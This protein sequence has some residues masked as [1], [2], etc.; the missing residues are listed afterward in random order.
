MD[1]IIKQLTDIKNKL[2]KPFPYKDTD[3]IQEDFRVEFLNLSEEE[4]CLTGDFNTY[5]MNIAGTLSYVLSGKTDKIPKRQIE[6]LQ[7]SFFDFFNQYKFFEE[8]INNYL[9][10]Y[11]EYKNFEETRKLLLQ[12]VK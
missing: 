2:D 5:C 3:R 12:V 6:I 11:G 4:D 1:N 10:F 8:K 9:D 7:M